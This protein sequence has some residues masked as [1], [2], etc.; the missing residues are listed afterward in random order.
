MNPKLRAFIQELW[1]GTR[2]GVLKWT[3][4]PEKGMYRLLLD[5]GLVR[6]YQAKANL[7]VGCTVLNADGDVIHEEEIVRSDDLVLAKLYDQVERSLQETALDDLL[8]E[9]RMKVQKNGQSAPA[10][11]R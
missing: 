6:I 4:T 2:A 11:Q 3:S 10:G 1:E 7:A 5:K 9:V 8:A